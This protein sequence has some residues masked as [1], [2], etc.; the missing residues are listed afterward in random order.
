MGLFSG[1]RPTDLGV[2]NGRLKPMPASPNAVSSQAPDAQHAIAPLAYSRTR[3]EAMQALIQIIESTPRAH[4][5][6]RE[7]DYLYVEYTSALM[8]F[9]DDVEFYFPPDAKSIHV[10]SASRLGY[11]DFGVNRAR[12]E[13]I[14]RWLTA[15]GA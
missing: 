14:R 11:R 1:K 15:S 6:T 2:D 13:D 3:E 12:I 9:V 8:R 4:I 5:V 7:S 10:R